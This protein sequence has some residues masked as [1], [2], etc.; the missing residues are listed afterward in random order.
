MQSERSAQNPPR[1]HPSDS[2]NIQHGT[3]VTGPRARSRMDA[4]G[5]REALDAEPS[6]FNEGFTFKHK[7]LSRSVLQLHRLQQAGRIQTKP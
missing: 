4:D 1:D 5:Y 3:K 2:G 6:R 7:T